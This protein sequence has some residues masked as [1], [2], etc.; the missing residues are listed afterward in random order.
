MQ[1][2]IKAINV[3]NGDCI[4]FQI[5]D[6]D[7]SYNLLIDCGSLNNDVRKTVTE[8][9][10]SVI[11]FL[12]VTHIDEVHIKGVCDLL[13]EM[14]DQLV[15][16]KIWFNSIQAGAKINARNLT[17]TEAMSIRMLRKTFATY[18]TGIVGDTSME[19]AK[20]LTDYILS[21]DEWSSAWDHKEVTTELEPFNCG[22]N[23]KFGKVT[24]LSP[25]VNYW[26]KHS[27]EYKNLFKSYLG[28]RNYENLSE[29]EFL[30]ELLSR[31]DLHE[32]LQDE[33]EVIPTSAHKLTAESIRNYS[34]IYKPISLTKPNQC[35]IAFVWELGNHKVL[36]LGDAHPN[37]VATE[38]KNKL[39]NGN[40]YP[41]IFDAIKVA[42]HGSEHNVSRNLLAVSD[43][44]H[45]IITGGEDGSNPAYETIAR[46]ICNKIPMKEGTNAFEKR[47]IL[48][49]RETDVVKDYM[50]SL[51][52]T[53]EDLHYTISVKSIVEYG[54]E[55]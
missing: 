44:E 46:I 26:K 43:S 31:I 1:A 22:A 33:D 5:K 35:S 30:Y 11:D 15:I 45:F 14:K 28:K 49:N 42:H 32:N 4:A 36:F 3:G 9:F 40:E 2:T 17:E 18:S 37:K 50:N 47:E 6:E 23:G 25:D 20:V 53:S 7:E 24:V 54:F 41:V 51:P 48:C 8:D 19:D 55:I 16:H 10:N 39:Q 52:L 12:I 21:K 38:I 27:E 13:N 34:Q 29:C